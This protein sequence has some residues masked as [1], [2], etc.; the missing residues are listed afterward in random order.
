M[1][2]YKTKKLVLPVSLLVFAVYF[3]F[4]AWVAD[5]AYIT[6][7]TVENLHS[8]YGLRWNI[9]ER[10]QSYTHP[11]WMIHLVVGKYIIH[12]L[13]YLSLALGLLY[14]S[15]TIYFLYLLTNKYIIH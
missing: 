5:D 3:L 4:S 11:L 6:F 13:Y 10:V 8:G 9:I 7:R 15:L 14:T 1:S 12:D 2:F